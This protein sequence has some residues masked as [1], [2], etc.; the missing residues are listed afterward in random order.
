MAYEISEQEWENTFGSGQPVG[1]WNTLVYAFKNIFS[2]SNDTAN[3]YSNNK[4]EDNTLI[5]VM[6]IFSVIILLIVLLKG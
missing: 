3:T 5:Y 4:K 1:F 2:N 6:I